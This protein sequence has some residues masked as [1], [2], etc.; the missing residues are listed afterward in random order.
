MKAKR[1][2]REGQPKAR[3]RVWIVFVEMSG[4]GYRRRYF[5]DPCMKNEDPEFG[6]KFKHELGDAL[7]SDDV[8]PAEFVAAMNP[9]VLGGNS[10]AYRKLVERGEITPFEEGLHKLAEVSLVRFIQASEAKCHS[11]AEV[12]LTRFA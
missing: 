7:C 6:S 8:D 4:G 3:S 2:G 9:L 10:D 12:S 5:S 1:I 11:W